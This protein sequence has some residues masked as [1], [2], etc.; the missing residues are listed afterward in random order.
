MKRQ[1]IPF[2]SQ[3]SNLSTRGTTPRGSLH[4]LPIKSSLSY[5]KVQVINPQKKPIETKTLKVNQLMSEPLDA[6][7]SLISRIINQKDQTIS[8]FEI[9][10]CASKITSKHIIFQQTEKMLQTFLEEKQLK[11]IESLIEIQHDFCELT[12]KL[13]HILRYLGQKYRT[14]PERRSYFL[15]ENQN[16]IFL[17]TLFDVIWTNSIQTEY[18]P[19][20]ET[21]IKQF[22]SEISEI[23]KEISSTV[24]QFL[25]LFHNFSNSFTITKLSF[26]LKFLIKYYRI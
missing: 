17:N 22:L 14:Y 20:F 5:H 18:F 9:S 24:S 8:F 7:I 1:L 11:S 12:V 23:G 6:M 21:E 13:K 19:I 16:D 26:S 3:S 15:K 2:K 25:K 4:S 10:D